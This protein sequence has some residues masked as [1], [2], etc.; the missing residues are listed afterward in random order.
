MQLLIGRT[1]GRVAYT[2]G[3]LTAG[4]ASRLGSAETTLSW[5][6]RAEPPH[7]SSGRMVKFMERL[8]RT[9]PPERGPYTFYKSRLRRRGRRRSPKI[10]SLSG[11]RASTI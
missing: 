7:M 4:L 1:M 2:V 10:T 9:W 8:L 11:A 6:K 5:S 3:N